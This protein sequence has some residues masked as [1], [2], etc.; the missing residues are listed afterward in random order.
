MTPFE[1]FRLWFARATVAQKSGTGL[2]ITAVVAVLAWTII[3]PSTSGSSASTVSVGGTNETLP[4]AGG[5]SSSTVSSTNGANAVG[6]N[7]VGVSNGVAGSTGGGAVNAVGPGGSSSLGSSGSGTSSR[8]GSSNS[9]GNPGQNTV[10]GGCVSPPGTAPGVT[11]SQVKVAAIIS[12]I[13]EG[14][15]NINGALGVGSPQQQQ[16]LYQTVIDATNASGGVACRKL[17]PEY[18]TVNP[19]DSS[20]EQATCLNIASAGVFAVVDTGGMQGELGCFDQH[21][22]PYFGGFALLYADQLKTYYPYVF[23]ALGA[24]DPLAVNTV[25]GL[26]QRGYFSKA[27]GFVKVG[28]PYIETAP[29][30]DRTVINEMMNAFHQ[31]GLTNSQI[32]TYDFGCS[33]GTPNPPSDMENAILKFQQAG[34]T[35]VV[36]AGMGLD[37]IEFTDIAQQQHFKPKYGLSDAFLALDSNA[38]DHPDYNNI[39]G[40][41]VITDSRDGQEKTAGIAENAAT[42]RCSALMTAH[43]FASAYA[44]YGDGVVC[45]LITMFAATI[46]HV[47]TISQQALPTGLQAVKSIDLAF[48]SG[49]NDFTGAFPTAGGEF[50]RTLQ[51]EANCTCTKVIDPTFHQSFQPWGP[52]SDPTTTG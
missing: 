8:P 29:A 34:V 39:D 43:G 27:N 7:G 11:G 20:N 38:S 6:A 35:H 3:P 30:C 42:Q 26:A 33:A 5:V 12:N 15:T 28:F 16:G 4:G 52:L 48:P 46:D 10:G 17:V 36:T 37:F 25:F 21:H 44:N 13:G 50:W 45:D 23:T 51:F 40:A 41:I 1:R 19:A 22:L 49:P 31:I 14:G 9:V 24:L 2:V 32:V 18:F 47:S